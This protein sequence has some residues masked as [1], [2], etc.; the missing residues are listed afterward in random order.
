MRSCIAIELVCLNVLVCAPMSVLCA[1]SQCPWP[2]P[3]PRRMS[4]CHR[5]QPVGPSGD[6]MGWAA[7]A[8]VFANHTTEWGETESLAC[9]LSV[10]GRGWA[11]RRTFVSK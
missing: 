7:V 8:D 6:P 5:V 3:A 11:L 10:L 2:R 9:M 4:N 1:D